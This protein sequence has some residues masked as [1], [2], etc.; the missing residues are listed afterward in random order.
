[1]L[2]IIKRHAYDPDQGARHEMKP[3]AGVS[4]EREFLVAPAKDPF[5]DTVPGRLA[6]V[7]INRHFYDYANPVRVVLIA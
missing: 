2:G 1:V 4:I 6:A 5:T 7:V 3:V